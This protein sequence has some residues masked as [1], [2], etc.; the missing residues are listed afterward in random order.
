MSSTPSSNDEQPLAN[1]A[2]ATVELTEQRTELPRQRRIRSY[3]PTAAMLNGRPG[4]AINLAAKRQ[5]AA[6]QQQRVMVQ[7]ALETPEQTAV[8]LLKTPKE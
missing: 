2:S 5:I 8:R 7:R 1:E 6:R 4:N 3:D